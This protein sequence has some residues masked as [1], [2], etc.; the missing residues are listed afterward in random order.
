MIVGPVQDIH[1]N[2]IKMTGDLE[3]AVPTQVM[4]ARRVENQL[5]R[6]IYCENVILKLNTKLGE[7]NTRVASFR[8]SQSRTPDIPFILKQNIVLGADVTHPRP[9]GKTPCVAALVG[10][11]D[12]S[13]PVISSLCS[14]ALRFVIIEADRM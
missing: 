12:L 2:M 6:K 10:S 1:Y 4:L 8:D 13:V 11:R 7:K 14:T 9:G 5:G 3:L